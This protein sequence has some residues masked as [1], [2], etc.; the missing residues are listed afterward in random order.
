MADYVLR[1]LSLAGLF[2]IFFMCVFFFCNNYG[3]PLIHLF[4]SLEPLVTRNMYFQDSKI[5]DKQLTSGLRIAR[6]NKV[7]TQILH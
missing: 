5:G 7:F 6:G 4:S 3:F 1:V 2:F